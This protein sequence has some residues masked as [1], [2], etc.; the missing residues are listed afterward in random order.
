MSSRCLFRL[1]VAGATAATGLA[2]AAPAVA[3]VTYDPAT[4]TGFI[5]KFA[6]RKAFGWTDA[7]LTERAAAVGFAH[8]FSTADT[9]AISCGG[10]TFRVVHL[11][12]SG[13]FELADTVAHNRTRGAR[14]GYGG[15]LTG[16]HLTGAR[17]GISG[18][19]VP[20][21]AGQP[22]PQDL[23]Q[24][25]GSTVDRARPVSSATRWALVA[26]FGDVRRVLLA[27]EAPAPLPG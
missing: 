23:G 8:D 7:M 5:D 14:I 9:Y 24:A 3:S 21:A 16:F 26:G 4:M 20:P 2:F 10:P 22:C 11:R 17:S 18:T 12:E 19:S 25:P 15:R 1:A 13:T 27:E 6:V